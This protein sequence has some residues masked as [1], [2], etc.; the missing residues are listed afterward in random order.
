MV[1][2]LNASLFIKKGEALIKKSL[3]NEIFKKTIFSYYL[4]YGSYL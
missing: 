2:H 1:S 4:Y 3:N